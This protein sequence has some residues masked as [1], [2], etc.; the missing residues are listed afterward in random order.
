MNY[1]VPVCARA[2]VRGASYAVSPWGCTASSNMVSLNEIEDE[3]VRRIETARMYQRVYTA[4]QFGSHVTG[5]A[6]T[7]SIVA[8][9]TK[10]FLERRFVAVPRSPFVIG[11]LVAVTTVCRYASDKFQ[12]RANHQF[13]VAKELSILKYHQ[14]R[15]NPDDREKH[16]SS[17]FQFSQLTAPSVRD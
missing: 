3:R 1:H 2:R 4:T 5:G 12:E 11:G 7:G 9:A 17:D 10:S 6:L 16:F 15:M 13:W 14:D 8:S